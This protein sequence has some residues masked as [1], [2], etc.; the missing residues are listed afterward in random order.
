MT[1]ICSKV[2][3]L[4]KEAQKTIYKQR[5]GWAADEKVL[6]RALNEMINNLGWSKLTADR[7]AIDLYK[8]PITTWARVRGVRITSLGGHRTGKG[9]IPE[10]LKK[11]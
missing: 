3:G 8:I 5:G 11:V 6:T 9:T 4:F 1:E 2:D 10:E 7:V